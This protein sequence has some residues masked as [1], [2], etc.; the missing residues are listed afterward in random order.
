M[1]VMLGLFKL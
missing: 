1:D